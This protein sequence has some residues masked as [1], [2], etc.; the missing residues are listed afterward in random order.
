MAS[1]FRMRRSEERAERLVVT[2]L[3]EGS[4]EVVNALGVPIRRLSLRDGRGCAYEAEDVRPGE[5]RLLSGQASAAPAKGSARE[6]VR[7]LYRADAPGWGITPLLKKGAETLRPTARTYV[8]LL[9]GCP[10]LENPLGYRAVK[11]SAQ[12]LVAGR[13]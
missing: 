12:A 1:I 11:E 5:K 2:E 9:E 3:G 7:A 4:V 10:F 13:Y 8:A 6:Q